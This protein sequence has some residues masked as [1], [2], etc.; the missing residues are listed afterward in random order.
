M[1]MRLFLW[2]V[3]NLCISVLEPSISRCCSISRPSFDETRTSGSCS[4][5]RAAALASV[6]TFDDAGEPNKMF[7]VGVALETNLTGVLAILAILVFSRRKPATNDDCS[8]EK[9]S[10]FPVDMFLRLPSVFPLS[11]IYRLDCSSRSYQPLVH[12]DGD[13]VRLNGVYS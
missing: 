5:S 11:P 1:L 12:H 3:G 13:N 7:L 9:L 4:C 8:C 6:R 2:F 10:E